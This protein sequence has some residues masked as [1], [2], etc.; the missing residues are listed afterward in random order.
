MP[1][2]VYHGK[3]GIIYNVTNTAVG[4]LVHKKVGNRY[5]EKRV[6]VRTEH[7]R[8]SK[9]RE[10]FVRRVKDN[11]ARRKA[12]KESGDHVTIKRQLALPRGARTVSTE[13]NIPA[14]ITPIP[15]ETTI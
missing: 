15:Y 9:C 6:N 13:D 7:V 2:K 14:T 3:T 10:E 8:H 1:Y 11:A 4:V 12:A 5:I